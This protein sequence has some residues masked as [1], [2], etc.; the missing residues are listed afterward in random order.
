MNIK[1][2]LK[3]SFEHCS[4][5]LEVLRDFHINYREWKHLNLNSHL[6]FFKIHYY[7]RMATVLVKEKY[8]EKSS[9]KVVQ[10]STDLS[11]QENH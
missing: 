8:I 1:T 7:S 10:V 6:K 3:N 4:A 9:I 5:L 11:F 2:E